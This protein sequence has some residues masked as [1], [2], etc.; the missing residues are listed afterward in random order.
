MLPPRTSP[1]AAWP[2]LHSWLSLPP[3]RSPAQPGLVVMS[4]AVLGCCCIRA[5]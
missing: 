2:Q 1:L 3:C 4:A 5:A